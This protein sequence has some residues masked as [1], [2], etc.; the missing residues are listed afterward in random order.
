MRDILKRRF[1]FISLRGIRKAYSSALS[2]KYREAEA[3]HKALA[4]DSLDSLSVMRNVIVHSAGIADVDY[5][6]DCKGLPLV[7]QLKAGEQLILEGEGCATLLDQVYTCCQ[8]FI[9]AVD[10]WINTPRENRIDSG[11]DSVSDGVRRV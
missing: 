7:P 3:I 8:D 2:D 9:A 4:N 5:V 6:R 10:N 11:L 1:R